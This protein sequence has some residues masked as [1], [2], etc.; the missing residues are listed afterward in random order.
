MRAGDLL[1]LNPVL[2]IGIEAVLRG[3]RKAGR[4]WRAAHRHDRRRG[5]R[6]SRPPAQAPSRADLPCRSNQPDERLRKIAEVSQG[7][8]YAISRTGITGAQKT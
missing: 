2:R 6:L 8:V 4:R 7:F 1:L 3:R 5:G